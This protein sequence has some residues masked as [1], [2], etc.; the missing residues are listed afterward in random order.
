MG[1]PILS[2]LRFPLGNPGTK[3]HLMLALWPGTEYT[4][5][6]K[7]V[8][9]PKSEPWWVL[10]VRVFPWLVCAPKCSNYALT[11]LLFGLCKSMWISELLVNLLNPIPELQHALLPLKC[12]KPRNVPQLLLL[13]LFSLLDSLLNP[14]RSLKV[15]HLKRQKCVDA[16]G[17]TPKGKG[18]YQFVKKYGVNVNNYSPVYTPN[19]WSETSNS[20]VGSIRPVLMFDLV[21]LVSSIQFCSFGFVHPLLIIPI[22]TLYLQIICTM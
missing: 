11:N 8:A 21:H 15:R 6:G 14:S 3:W 22:D 19:E 18:V 4:I 17:R 5:R 9:S 20:Y 13:P 2:I 16:L 12:Y 10:W 7:V 1:V